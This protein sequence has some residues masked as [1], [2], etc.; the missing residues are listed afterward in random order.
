MAL[1]PDPGVVCGS[2]AKVCQSVVVYLG[3]EAQQAAVGGR[4]GGGG[5]AGQ[6]VLLVGTLQYVHWP[7]L[8]VCGVFHHLSVENQVWGRCMP[9]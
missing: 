6:T 3:G 1:V 7:V 4:C 8:Q 2:G 5:A 9:G